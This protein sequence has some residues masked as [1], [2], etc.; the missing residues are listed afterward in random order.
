VLLLQLLVLVAWR[1]YVVFLRASH[2]ITTRMKTGKRSG[3][4]SS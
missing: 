2:L 4:R 1:T 3:W